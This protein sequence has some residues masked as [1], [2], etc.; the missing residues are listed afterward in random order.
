MDARLET[1]DEELAAGRRNWNAVSIKAAT[2]MQ[3]WHWIDACNRSIYKDWQSVIEVVNS[4]DGATCAAAA[5]GKRKGWP[6][7]FFIAGAEETGEPVDVI[8][9]DEHAAAQLARRVCG[10]GGAIRFGHFPAHSAFYRPF[11]VEGRKAGIVLT[12]P[13]N[14]SP[15]LLLDQSWC[16]PLARFSSRRRSDFRRMMR[17]AEKMG[18]VSFDV[19]SPTPETVDAYLD[20]AIAVEARSWKSRSKTAI[21]DN[22]RQE[23]FYREF[24]MLA[25]QSGILRIGQMKIDEHHAAMQLAVEYENAFWLFKIGYDESFSACS[26]G[27]LMMME[28]IR[29]AAENGLTSY[30]FLGKSAAWTRFW[31]EDERPNAA[32]RFY[33]HNLSGYCCLIKDGAKIAIGRA[34]SLWHTRILRQKSGQ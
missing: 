29:R 7:Q 30:E 19:I 8:Y 31:T 18:D 28:S 16:D 25:A 12:T 33:P 24:A 11:L 23:S 5:F 2:P 3:S 20:Q 6:R 4:D 22:K 10:L 15:Y 13:V 14:G 21:A 1:F 26:P 9:Q 17:K 27:N 34:K 32:L